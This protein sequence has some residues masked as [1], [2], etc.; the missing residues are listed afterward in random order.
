M[1]S[2]AQYEA[3]MRREAERK[4]KKLKRKP[5]PTKGKGGLA[6][7]INKRHQMLADI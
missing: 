2:D 5:K 7:R 1:P 6:D 4:K 3:A